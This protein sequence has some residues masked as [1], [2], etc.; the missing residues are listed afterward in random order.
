MGQFYYSWKNRSHFV[1]TYMYAS[2]FS[3]AFI[4]KCVPQNHKG[5]VASQI[6]NSCIQQLKRQLSQQLLWQVLHLLLH[7]HTQKTKATGGVS[8][9][10][11]MRQF[12]YN[13]TNQ[14]DFSTPFMYSLFGWTRKVWLN[15]LFSTAKS[16]FFIVFLWGF[17]FFESF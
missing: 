5:K 17:A 3:F 10:S 2:T 9:H 7:Y 15:S 8:I 14:S 4:S 12:A 1:Y 6:Y 16:C 13:Q 11:C